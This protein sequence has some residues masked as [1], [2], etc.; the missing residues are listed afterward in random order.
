ST[1]KIVKN[2]D[3][4]S[5]RGKGRAKVTQI[6]DITKKGKIKVQARLIV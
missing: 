5:I 4:I 6:G 1:S 3:L 2:D